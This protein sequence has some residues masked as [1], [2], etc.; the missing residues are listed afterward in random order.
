[1][2][3]NDSSA[4]H[5]QTCTAIN[6]ALQA[7]RQRSSATATSATAST[8]TWVMLNELVLKKRR[9]SVLEN[10]KSELAEKFHVMDQIRDGFE[11]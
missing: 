7:E 9:R 8:P 4:A 6:S 10:I 5:L 2:T 3:P 11:M 1:M